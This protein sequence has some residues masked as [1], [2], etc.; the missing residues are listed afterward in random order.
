M[1][2]RKIINFYKQTLMRIYQ[3]ILLKNGLK[4]MINQREITK[5]T[6]KLEL[7]H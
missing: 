1:E 7:K 2:F 4:F 6:K 5:L 3:D